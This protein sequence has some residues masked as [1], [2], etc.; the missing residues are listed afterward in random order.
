MLKKGVVL[1]SGLA[2]L[3]ATHTSCAY[4]LDT[5]YKRGLEAYLSAYD[6]KYD[7]DTRLVDESRTI[8][9]DVYRSVYEIR[10]EGVVNGQLVI[11]SKGTG[12]VLKGGY[13]FTA[14]HIGDIKARK[15][16]PPYV[17]DF[18]FYVTAKDKSY[19]VRLVKSDLELDYALM[20]F[21]DKNNSLPPYKYSFGNSDELEIGDVL[22]I[23]G[24]SMGTGLQFK[25]SHVSSFETIMPHN[26]KVFGGINPGD[27]GGP[28]F[29]L[30]DGEPEL[31]GIAILK[32]YPG[33]DIGEYL[34]I[35]PAKEQIKDYIAEYLKK[36][37]REIKEP[38]NA[39]EGS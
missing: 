10:L 29:A 33:E 27:S 12:I 28:A 36:D 23:Y 19:E 14:G 17:R 4:K 34:K 6:N 2:L 5:G 13:F 9:E 26:F 31:V 39:P 24:N 32:V 3:V 38:S 7:N 11:F 15:N 25:E 1:L 18:H 21:V 22:Y 16:P 30:R 20:E 35:N 8:V 37:A